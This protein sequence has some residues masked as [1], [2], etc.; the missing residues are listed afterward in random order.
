MVVEE[1]GLADCH[2]TL[3]SLRGGGATHSFR[4]HRNL[5]QL[6]YAG[7]W[8]RAETLKHYI[9]EALAVQVVSQAPQE[10]QQLLRATHA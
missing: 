4:V 3:G 9:Q 2:F 7:R 1:L 5:G 8:K 10:S 6:Q